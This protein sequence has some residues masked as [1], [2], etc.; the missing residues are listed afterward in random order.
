MAG[1][2]LMRKKRE[3]EAESSFFDGCHFVLKLFSY[4][5]KKQ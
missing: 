4:D 5:A 1:S 3:K 2:F